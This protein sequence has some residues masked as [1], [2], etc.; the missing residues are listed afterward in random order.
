M[1]TSLVHVGEDETS[2]DALFFTLNI[3]PLNS[4][5][6]CA[7]FLPPP[8]TC[9][10]FT[11]PLFPCV[12]YDAI[13]N[14]WKDECREGKNGITVL[15]SLPFFFPECSYK[16]QTHECWSARYHFRIQ[17]MQHWSVSVETKNSQSP[18]FFF[19]THIQL[20]MSKENSQFSVSPHS[21]N[22]IESFKCLVIS[23]EMLLRN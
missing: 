5:N 15:E 10:S 13:F 11:R 17:G 21:P 6:P 20:G 9:L 19:Q 3:A 22:M 14:P 16:Q 1:I 7:F 2:G 12:F 8:S 4:V 23:R 18:P